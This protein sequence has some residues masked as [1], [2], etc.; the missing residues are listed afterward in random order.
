MGLTD[1]QFKTA[2][3]KDE[4]NQLPFRNKRLKNLLEFVNLY[5]QLAFGKPI[6]VTSI[7]R[8]QEE[9]DALYAQ[10]PPDQKPP[11]SPHQDWCAADLRSSIYTPYEIDRLV[12]ALNT[13]P[14]WGGQRKAALYHT[15][16]G[17]VAHLHI[18]IDKG[19]GLV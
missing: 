18:Q 11:R 9:Q 3:I 15:I 13:I 6:M 19:D 4:Y 17:N 12:A 10:T 1:S 2:R 8:S 14:V 16:A 5:S 7:F